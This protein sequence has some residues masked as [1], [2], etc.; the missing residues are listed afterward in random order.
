MRIVFVDGYNVINSWPELKEIKEYSYESAREKLLDIMRNYSA[1]CGYKIEVVFDA[2]MVKGAYEKKEKNDKVSVV[3]TKEGETADAYIEKKVNLIGRKF[4]VYVVTSDSLEQQVT[5]QR[6]A[7][8][9]SSLEFY[10]EVM[11]IEGKIGKKCEK[12]YSQKRNLFEDMIDE[13]IAKIL[14]KMRRSQ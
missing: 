7:S 3:F 10:H 9:M 11:K 2:H 4:E 1:F 14:E 12:V 6:G 5:F 13:D 8:R